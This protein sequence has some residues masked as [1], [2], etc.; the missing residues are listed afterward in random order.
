MLNSVNGITVPDDP[1]H[2]ETLVN[3]SRLSAHQC[4]PQEGMK[5]SVTP[6][7]CGIPQRPYDKPFNILIQDRV[8][9]TSHEVQ[10]ERR[11]SVDTNE[12][13]DE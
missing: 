12:R 5:S 9:A 8:L 2:S 4:A 13:D 1:M 10:E 6:S 3:M 7:T 11:H